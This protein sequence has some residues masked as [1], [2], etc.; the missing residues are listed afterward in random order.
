VNPSQTQLAVLNNVHWHEAFFAAH[1]LSSRLD[2]RVWL[3]REN[4][5]AYHSNLVVVSASI[6]HEDI[7]AYTLDLESRSRLRGWSIKDSYASLNLSSSGF[8]QLFGAEWI[9]RDPFQPVTGKESAHLVWAPLANQAELVEWEDAWSGDATNRLE[10]RITRQFPENLLASPN[11]V[12]FAGRRD[13][14]VVAGG[15]ANRSGGVVGLSN[16]FC[17]PA[18]TDEKWVALV[19]C[20]LAAFPNTPLVGYARNAELQLAMSVGFAPIGP[21][22]VWLRS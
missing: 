8:T 19:S 10:S 22:H 6:S 11:R 15:I 16:T 7:E 13:G 20:A 1:G 17:A 9:W 2:E 3:C 18:H 14:Q 21:L 4:A 12:F 5:P